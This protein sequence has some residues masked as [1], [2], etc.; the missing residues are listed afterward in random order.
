MRRRAVLFDFGGVLTSSVLEAFAAFGE[1]VCGNRDLPL[2]LLS[3]DPDAQAVLADHEK[4]LIDHDGFE[5]GFASRLQAHG[6]P[7]Q[8]DGLI[9]A[10]QAGLQRDEQMVALVAALRFLG[11]PVGLVSNSLGRDCYAGYDLAA[12]F[13]A[14][15]IS[16]REGVRKPSRRLFQIGCERLGVAPNETVMVDDLQHNIDAAERL[17]MAGILHRGAG[18]TTAAI[19]LLLDVDEQQLTQHM[20]LNSC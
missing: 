6:S 2:W 3:Q 5:R 11:V 18:E 1:H 7:V 16:G 14:V 15:T 8:A 9:A 19:A 20:N 17:G 4:G 10:I 12:M 13:D